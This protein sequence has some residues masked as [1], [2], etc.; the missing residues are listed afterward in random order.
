MV[1]HLKGSKFQYKILPNYITNG[2]FSQPRVKLKH[3]LKLPRVGLATMEVLSTM[4]K[5]HYNDMRIMHQIPKVVF[6]PTFLRSFRPHCSKVS[7]G[8]QHGTMYF[9]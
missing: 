7:H 8:T 6:V 1:T 5:T 2:I 9:M 3:T 4:S